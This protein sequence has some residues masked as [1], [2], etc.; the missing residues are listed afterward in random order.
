MRFYEAKVCATAMLRFVN[1]LSELLWH[2]K[3]RHLGQEKLFYL[4]L[5]TARPEVLI[6][7]AM[8]KVIRF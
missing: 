6:I 4:R 3:K 1:K 7:A 8:K 2:E 5:N